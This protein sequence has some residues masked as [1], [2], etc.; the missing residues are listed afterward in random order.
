MKDRIHISVLT[1]T[2]KD[3]LKFSK[4]KLWKNNFNLNRTGKFRSDSFISYYS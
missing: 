2:I 3:N 4:I 1:T